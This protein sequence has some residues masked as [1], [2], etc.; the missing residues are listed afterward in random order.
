MSTTHSAPTGVER[1]FGVDELIVSKTDPKGRITYANELFVRMSGF[2]RHELLGAPHSIIRHPDMPR[3]VFKLLWDSLDAG[4][5]VFACVKNLS[6][7]G[8]FYWVFAHVTPTLDASGSLVGHH[9]NRR[10]PDRS[11]I[12]AIEPL[13]AAMLDEEARHARAEAAAASFQ[14]LAR[15]LRSRET[16]YEKLI[17]SIT[18]S[19]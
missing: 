14:L 13:Y 19:L 11:A 12:A 10:C 15:E 17:F 16:S 8:D 4:R 2:T 5:E 7:N 3:G 1:T 9:S 6:K 18:G